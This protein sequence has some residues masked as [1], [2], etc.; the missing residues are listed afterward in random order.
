MRAFDKGK[1][2]AAIIPP[3]S[4]DTEYGPGSAGCQPVLF[5]SLPK[6][7]SSASCQRLQASGLRSPEQSWGQRPLQFHCSAPLITSVISPLA[8]RA[9]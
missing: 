2:V 8:G 1:S 3:K 4:G 9:S 5:G 7:V 6:S